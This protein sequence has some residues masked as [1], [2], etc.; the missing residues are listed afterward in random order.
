MKTMTMVYYKPKPE[1]FYLYVEA[2]KKIS[3]DSYILTRDEEVI[4]IWI[5]DSIED[6][7]EAQP[8]GL[9]WLDEHRHMLQEYS[10]AEGHT[11]PYTAFIE[12]E[13]NFLTQTANLPKVCS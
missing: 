8:E 4:E 1:Y 13:P 3:P 9:D 7:T 12:Q 5:M 10:R 6:L 2:L 11:R